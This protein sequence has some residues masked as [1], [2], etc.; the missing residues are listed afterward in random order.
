V[1]A[2]NAAPRLYPYLL[3]KES[4]EACQIMINKLSKDE[5]P[6]VRYETYCRLQHMVQS[7]GEDDPKVLLDFIVPILRR[8]TKELQD[9]FRFNIIDVVIAMLK[10]QSDELV[11]VCKEFL[12]QLFAD[13]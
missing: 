3:T 13:N 8:L 12:V 5:M 1:S 9:Y 2:A 11:N 4:K 6:M 10:V 7:L